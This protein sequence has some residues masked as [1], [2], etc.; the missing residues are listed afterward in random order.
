MNEQNSM[1]RIVKK[2]KRLP[3]EV[4]VA[5]ISLKGLWPEKTIKKRMNDVLQIMS[6]SKA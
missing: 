2:E 5:A 4:W 1:N 6:G 3:R